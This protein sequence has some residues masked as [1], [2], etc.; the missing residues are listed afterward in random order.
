M[1]IFEINNFDITL[2]TPIIVLHNEEI[3]SK[4]SLPSSSHL[5]LVLSEI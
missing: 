4:L 5:V 1:F 3:E 2:I